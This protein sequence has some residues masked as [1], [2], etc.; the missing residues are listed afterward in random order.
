MTDRPLLKLQHFVVQPVL[1]LDDGDDTPV[2]SVN[3]QI[4]SL[5][6]L[7]RMVAD[8]DSHLAALQ[9]DYDAQAA[10]V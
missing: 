4:V 7:R 8:W 10:R 5:P 3:P 1:V 2:P 9:E 6:Q